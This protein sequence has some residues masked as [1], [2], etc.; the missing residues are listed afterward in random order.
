MGSIKS[1]G[2]LETFLQVG[3]HCASSDDGQFAFLSP[4]SGPRGSQLKL[5]QPYLSDDLAGFVQAGDEITV[6]V[7]KLG[8]LT[9]RMVAG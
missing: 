9:N 4:F 7:E 2:D 8:K 6:E 1:C 3:G 5:V